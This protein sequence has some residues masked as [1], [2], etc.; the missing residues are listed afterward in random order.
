MVAA[1]RIHAFGGP[2]TMVYEPVEVGAPGAGEVR[3]RHK[4][5][6]LNYT[7]V[8]SRKG[9]PGLAPP[10]VLGAEGAG[11]V[12]AVGP[13][14]TDFKA[15]D[16]VAYAGGLGAYAEERLFPA[17]KLI[18]LPDAISYEQGAAMMLKGMTAWYL[19][20]RTYE[21]KSGTVLLLHAAA[22]GVGLI[23]SQWAAHL[24]GTVIGTVGTKDKVALAQANGCKHVIL[25][26]DEDFVARV[27]E[28]T[29]G[30][31]CHVVYDGVGQ[32][33]YPGSVDCLRSR[34][35]FVSF[36]NASGP[37]LNFDVNTLGP[38]GSLFVTRPMLPNYVETREELLAAARELCDAVVSGAVKIP[39]SKTY[40]LRDAAQAHRDL[41]A[42]ATTGSCVLVP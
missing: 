28:I 31:L 3:I 17:D 10:L 7:D 25:Y 30:K 41:E 4:A 29:Q 32:A 21:V 35:M 33:T 22:G 27:K 8:Y 5:I 34:G 18:K 37:I 40:A 23:L 20:R 38:K 36:G 11:D 14:V 24:G 12:V 42:R 26:R 15:G 19:V 2:E 1:V 39:V 13:G 16:R 6:G 9:R